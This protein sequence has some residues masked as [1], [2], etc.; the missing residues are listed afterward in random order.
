MEL[1]RLP[2]LEVNSREATT[3]IVLPYGIIKYLFPYWGDIN[4][5]ITGKLVQDTAIWD[6]LPM[7]PP[8]SI[9]VWP[10]I[11]PS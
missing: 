10:F 11:L 9:E 3:S 2:G 1:D 4:W 6:L 7:Y 8:I 5:A